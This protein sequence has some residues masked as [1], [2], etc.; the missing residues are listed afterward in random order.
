[1]HERQKINII[2]CDA[3]LNIN[4]SFLA[5]DEEVGECLY[6]LALKRRALFSDDFVKSIINYALRS[7]RNS[8]LSHEDYVP[9]AQLINLFPEVKGDEET[10]LIINAIKIYWEANIEDY[11]LNS[12]RI[13]DIYD[14]RNNASNIAY[15]VLKDM[16]SEYD[17]PFM[18][19]D[20]DNI[21]ENIRMDNLCPEYDD[22]LA[23]RSGRI[24]DYAKNIS[25]DSASD[26]DDLFTR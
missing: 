21:F 25:R 9:L 23:D 16:I 18:E 2:D 12:Q 26:I 20:L 24:S 10:V 6:W 3:F 11:I 13:Q 14:D 17:L 5:Y 1:M 7:N 4:E 19:D 22:Y 15:E 8:T